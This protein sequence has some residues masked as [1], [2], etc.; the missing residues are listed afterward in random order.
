MKLR[1]LA[2]LGALPA[3]HSAYAA[4]YLST[5]QAQRAAFPAAT[6]FVPAEG[7]A[8]RPALAVWEARDATQRLG[9]LLVDRVIGRTEEITYALALDAAGTVLSLEVLE[10]RE[11]H[12]GEIRL[13]AWRRQFVG[14]SAAHPPQFGSDI[15]NI[16]GATLSCR[17]VS[18]GVAALLQFHARRLAAR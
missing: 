1:W 9:W 6:A 3:L 18:D 14:R 12:G 10:Y 5:E 15:R 11:T 4:V 7:D 8:A 17:H 16:V 13:P 2:A